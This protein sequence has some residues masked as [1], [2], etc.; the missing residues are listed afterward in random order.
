VDARTAAPRREELLGL[1]GDLPDRARPLGAQTIVREVH[2]HY[3][4]ETLRLDLAGIEP[5]PAYL[6]TPTVNPGK[7][8]PAVLFC[9]SHGGRY[10]LGKDELLQGN[11]YMTRPWVEDLTSRGWAVLAFDAWLFGGRRGVG[12]STLFK[13]TLWRGQ[14]LWGLMVYDGLRAMDYLSSRA[15]VDATRI[16]TLGMSMGSTLAWWLAALDQRVKVCV[17]I[18]CLTDFDSI[19][20]SPDI[21]GHS[22]YYFVPGL[23]KHFSTAQINELMVPRAHLALAGSHDPLTPLDGLRKVDAA[24]RAAYESAGAA[25]NWKLRIYD[26]GHQETP[27][28]RRDALTFLESQL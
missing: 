25:D 27:Q 26:T 1:L 10:E 15:D 14:T 9:H 17:D 7:P 11:T 20:D 6:A 12:E 28:M 21:D 2:D 22:F 4:L 16:A 19:V 23:L 24:L 13:R 8:V 3:I 5:V 18:C